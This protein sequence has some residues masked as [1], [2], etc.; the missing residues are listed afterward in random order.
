MSMRICQQKRVK[1]RASNLEPAFRD[2]LE[3][4]L[5]EEH[6]RTMIRW[7]VIRFKSPIAVDVAPFLGGEWYTMIPETMS[8]ELMSTA[9]EIRCD[10]AGWG[11]YPLYASVSGKHVSLCFLQAVINF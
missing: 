4:F 3:R 6:T 10:T 7:K 5:R 1:M 8:K 2:L 9:R 11:D